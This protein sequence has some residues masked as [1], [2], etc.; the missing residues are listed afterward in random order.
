MKKVCL[1]FIG[2]LILT[3]QSVSAQSIE[4]YFL[5]GNELYQKGDY[6]GAIEAY[7]KILQ[8]GYESWEVYYNLGNAYYKNKQIGLAILNYERAKRLNPENEDIEFN[9]S[10]A[11]LAIVDRIPALPK[12]FLFAWISNFTHLFSLKFLGILT[13]II[14]LVFITLILL[15]LFIKNRNFQKF[16]FVILV[17]NTTFLLI[18]GSMLV[19][20]IYENEN[21][22]EAILLA[23]KVDVLSAP[24]TAGT[25]L[26]TLHEGVK[27]QIKD[28]SGEWVKIRLADGKVGWVKEKYLAKI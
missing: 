16:S 7:N 12:F 13:I 5:K 24:G 21:K 25:E 15:R 20:R 23:D 27:L 2:F 22:V 18:F 17:I 26:F 28:R 8:A 1:F 10:L 11:N 14:Y 3:T 6:K 19:F 9:L 4:A